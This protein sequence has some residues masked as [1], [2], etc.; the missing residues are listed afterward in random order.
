MQVRDDV[1]GPSRWHPLSIDEFGEAVDDDDE[2][3]SSESI[4]HRSVS[5]E[6]YGAELF[7][8]RS[9]GIELVGI[10]LVGVELSV[11]VPDTV[12]PLCPETLISYLKVLPLSKTD[13]QPPSN[14]PPLSTQLTNLL[15]LFPQ[16][17]KSNEM[18]NG[19]EIANFN[20][21]FARQ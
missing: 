15:P 1:F 19:K 11:C 6:F 3:K 5:I 4:R 14:L 16:T 10:E 12:P 20:S 17:P 2:K 18:T 21:V 9:V 7:W 13:P 8:H